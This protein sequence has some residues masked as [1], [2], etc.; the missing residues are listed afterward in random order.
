MRV[1]KISQRTVNGMHR[2]C[3]DLADLCSRLRAAG[4]DNAAG[5]VDVARQHLDRARCDLEERMGQREVMR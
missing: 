2:T 1:R 3:Y 5:A 4:F